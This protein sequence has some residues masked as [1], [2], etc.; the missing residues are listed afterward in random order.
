[1]QLPPLFYI[2]CPQA[3]NTIFWKTQRHYS[4]GKWTHRAQ[5]CSLRTELMCAHF[6]GIVH[7][8]LQRMCTVSG[9]C[10]YCA[11]CQSAVKLLRGT[12]VSGGSSWW[13]SDSQW[14]SWTNGRPYCQ[15]WG[16]WLPGLH[17]PSPRLVHARE[18]T[19]LHTHIYLEIPPSNFGSPGYTSIYSLVDHNI[20]LY[21]L[22]LP[23]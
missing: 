21:T 17:Q 6:V 20:T 4:S 13:Y 10:A 15:R 18:G 19:P 23:L 16:R 14:Y 8:V 5:N 3:Y 22:C 1:M 2:M 11:C 9:N 12:V 7:F